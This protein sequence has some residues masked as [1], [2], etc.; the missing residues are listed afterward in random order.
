MLSSGHG[1]GGPY[2]PDNITVLS[3]FHSVASLLPITT[4]TTIPQREYFP[5]PL[6]CSV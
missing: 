2:A 5:T 3:L 4:P 1:G 6:H